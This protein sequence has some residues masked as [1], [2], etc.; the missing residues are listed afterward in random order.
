MTDGNTGSRPSIA[1]E[2]KGGSAYWGAE[3]RAHLT[4]SVATI[5][6]EGI[7]EITRFFFRPWAPLQLRRAIRK[8]LAHIRADLA[9]AA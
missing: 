9:Q 7:S 4:Y 2:A 3:A 6:M 5:R 1:P 8:K